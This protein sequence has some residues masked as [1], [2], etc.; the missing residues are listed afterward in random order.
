MKSLLFLISLISTVYA[1]VKSKKKVF[2]VNVLV[3]QEYLNAYEKTHP[4]L[5][6]DLMTIAL[7]LEAAFNNSTYARSNGYEVS[8]EIFTPVD[9]PLLLKMGLQVCEGSIKNILDL[10]NSV[11]EFDNTHHYILLLPCPPSMFTEVFNSVGVDVPVIEYRTNVECSKRIAMFYEA[12]YQQM[13]ASFSNALLKILNAPMFDYNTVTE[14][15]MGDDGL[16]VSVAL[17]DS[18]I[19]HIMNSK[20]FLNTRG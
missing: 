20:C 10:L 4:S 8:F 9:N 5:G 2:N 18:T 17:N 1:A 14:T 19:H 16:K 12:N 15:S 6:T 7:A 11:N 13:F 3:A